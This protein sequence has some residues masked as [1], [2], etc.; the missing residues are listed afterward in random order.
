VALNDGWVTVSEDTK[1]VL[2]SWDATS[3]RLM[4]RSVG[5]PAGNILLA[6]AHWVSRDTPVWESEALLGGLHTPAASRPG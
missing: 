3:K 5:E 6:R 4:V 2:F 1:E